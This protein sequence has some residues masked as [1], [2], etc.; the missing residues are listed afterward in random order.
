MLLRLE[1]EVQSDNLL[2]ANCTYHADYL[3]KTAVFL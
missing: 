1:N 3:P 2:D